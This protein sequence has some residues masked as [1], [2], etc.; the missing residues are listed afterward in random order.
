MHFFSLQTY[1]SASACFIWTPFPQTVDN[2]RKVHRGGKWKDVI[3]R[4][5]VWQAGRK[6]EDE[7]EDEEEEAGGNQR[8]NH[9]KADDSGNMVLFRGSKGMYR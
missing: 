3:V 1:E 2:R 6:E 7:E 4:A 8:N 9:W 5:P